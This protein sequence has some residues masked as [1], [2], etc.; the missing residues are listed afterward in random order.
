M[1]QRGADALRLWMIP[2]RHQ[3]EGVMAAAKL[4]LALCTGIGLCIA[5][6]LSVRAQEEKPK[7][8][9]RT[10]II[11]FS[12]STHTEAIEFNVS[13]D[14]KT[15]TFG[16]QDTGT[17][18]MLSNTIT[19]NRDGSGHFVS[20]VRSNGTGDRWCMR[21]YLRDHNDLDLYVYGGDFPGYCSPFDLQTASAGTPW[22]FDFFFPQHLFD[23]LTQAWRRDH[24]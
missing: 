20:Q 17:C 11:P 8:T 3:G 4:T 19:I 2:G 24:C 13:G 6:S 14:V 7:Q 5:M 22:N 1:R 9:Q 12:A 23:F 18:A 15:A 16:V 10:R 21:F